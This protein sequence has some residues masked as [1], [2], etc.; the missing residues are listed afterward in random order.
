[1]LTF[2][3]VDLTVDIIVAGSNRFIA[4]AR[5]NLRP[6]SEIHPDMRTTATQTY[7]WVQFTGDAAKCNSYA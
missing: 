1:M 6:M 3:R 5:Y 7:D 4:S 2:V